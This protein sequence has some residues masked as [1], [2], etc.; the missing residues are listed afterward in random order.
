MFGD[1]FGGHISGVV[2]FRDV[3]K[4]STMH[5]TAL[6]I[7]EISSPIVPRLRKFDLDVKTNVSNFF[8]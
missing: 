4:H 7:K 3:A 5:R 8:A 6:H 1:M 2:P